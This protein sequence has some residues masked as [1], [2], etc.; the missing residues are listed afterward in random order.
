MSEK[1]FLL[2]IKSVL[3]CLSFKSK[4]SFLGVYWWI[5]SFK[6]LDVVGRF[7]SNLDIFNHI[8][9]I[10]P[11]VVLFLIIGNSRVSVRLGN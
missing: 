2:V 11:E 1:K 4:I 10:F 9:S 7:E 5:K 8:D 3:S 6:F